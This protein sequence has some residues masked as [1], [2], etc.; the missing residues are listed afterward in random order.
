ME[1]QVSSQGCQLYACVV[2]ETI[3][4]CACVSMRSPHVILQVTLTH[5]RILSVQSTGHQTTAAA[6]G[7]VIRNTACLAPLWD[8][9]IRR[10]THR[11]ILVR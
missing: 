4:G 9:R 5:A 6:H 11:Q 1:L 2:R 10:F 3:S 7:T 8:T